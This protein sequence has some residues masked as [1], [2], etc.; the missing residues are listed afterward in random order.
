V[1]REHGD[2]DRFVQECEELAGAVAPAQVAPEPQ[3]A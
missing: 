3:G 2:T 1:E